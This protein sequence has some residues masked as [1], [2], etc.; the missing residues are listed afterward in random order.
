M[1]AENIWYPFTYGLG[2]PTLAGRRHAEHS[3][4]FGNCLRA[5]LP[6]ERMEIR[7]TSSGNNFREEKRKRRYRELNGSNSLRK[8]V[9]SREYLRREHFVRSRDASPDLKVNCAH[10]TVAV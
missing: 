8:R 1:P 5:L 2:E 7:E 9:R 6:R 4:G 10:T 3:C